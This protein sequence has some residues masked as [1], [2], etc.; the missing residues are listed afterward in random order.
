M[1]NPSAEALRAEFGPKSVVSTPEEM[2]PFLSDIYHEV[3]GAAAATLFP[4]STDEVQAMLRAAARLGL[5]VVPQGGNTGLVHGAV[6]AG[7]DQVIL[8][9]SRMNA[10][11]AIDPDD[12]SVTVESGCVLQTVKD[13]VAA[14]DLFLPVT[15]GSQGSCQIGGVVST[16][17]GGINVL[18]YGMARDQV[19]GL[20]VVLADGT[21]W[22]GLSSLRKNNTGPDLKQ[23]FIGAEGTFGVITAATLRLS[24]LP[25]RR[26]TA[27]VAM[28]D[29]AAVTK[30]FHLARRACA[31]LLSAFEFMM[32][33][34]MAVARDALPG[35]PDLPGPGGAYALID[36][37][38]PGPV[39][40]D[41]LM[42][43]FLERALEDGLI[44]DGVI[45]TSEAQAERLW[46]L[47]EAVNEGAARHGPHLRS[48][49]SARLRDLPAFVA[50]V[51][52]AITEGVPGARP[53]A[54]GHYGDGNVHVT[55]LPPPGSEVEIAAALGAAKEIL[56]ARV[57]AYGG[58][59]SAEHGI[60]RL[61]RADFA[62][63][64]APASR[65]LLGDLRAAL[66]PEGRMNPGALHP[67]AVPFRD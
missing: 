36:L 24:P 33:E 53:L 67:P 66:D 35:A 52:T 26:A 46:A 39:D 56:N 13:A 49:V 57:D 5:G 11:R 55:V 37:A 25:A 64:L 17:A 44:L 28:P 62:A 19:L 4:R 20:E 29:L 6:P 43:G 22:N 50:E 48:D 2:S 51:T 41:A 42:E 61:K 60:G 31:D 30:V 15:I 10:I 9:L 18:R 7:P 47:R 8:S 23:L 16:N 40:L 14:H 38:A 54:F 21:L 65:R 27:L 12:Y 3:T 34:A 58:S 1:T 59:I 32:P 45:A 63:R